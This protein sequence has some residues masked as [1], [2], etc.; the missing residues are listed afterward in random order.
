MR[1]GA[2][3]AALS[4]LA[5]G[6][7]TV[8]SQA[9]IGGTPLAI[10][11]VPWQ[12]AMVVQ[13]S[14]LCGGA[15]I[16][17]THVLTAAHCFNDAADPGSVRAYAGISRLSERASATPLGISGIAI[18][19]GFDRGTF[20][21]DLAI[22]TLTAPVPAT[23]T[24]GAI[25]LPVGLPAS[26]WP[27]VGEALRVSGWGRS[28]EGGR[29]SDQLLGAT[30]QLLAAPGAA[31]GQYG[32][33]QPPGVLCAGVPDGSID[34]CQGDS[35][36]PLVASLAGRPVLAGVTSVGVECA[37]SSY[38]G[39]YT[40]VASQLGWIGSVTGL[41]GGTAAPAD[42][43][44]TSAAP[45]QLAA[46]WTYGQGGASA[47][48]TSF[49]ASFTAS[50]RPTLTCTATTT[51]C[52]VEGAARRVGYA[53]SVTATGPLGVSAPAAGKGRTADL[54]ASAGRTIPVKALGVAAGVKG[55]RK[56]TTRTRTVC[57]PKGS[58]LRMVAPGTCLATV[59]APGRR[60]TAVIIV[61]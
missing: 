53:V 19:P 15:L 13:G 5:L 35:G 29:E 56:A 60:G 43:I 54:V 52:S 12:V 46:N 17:P 48:A 27:A 20:A 24:T 47:P 49:T 18:H 30:V 1:S 4:A 55:A 7:L 3:A 51:T 22:I 44:V 50:G 21:N 36:G 58:G 42:V 9:V 26:S 34:T 28:S 16:T 25:A 33:I 37:S 57:V 23:A 10:T 61:R 31:C 45:G 6:G 8:P 40:S 32:S 41:P 11:E 59:T 38:P 39:I 2:I 14:S